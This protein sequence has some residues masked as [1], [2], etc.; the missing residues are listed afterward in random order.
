MEITESNTAKML[1]KNEVD[2]VDIE[3]NIGGCGFA[4][5]VER[6]L[7]EKYGTNKTK[8]SWFHQSKNK[9]ARILSNS[10]WIMDHNYY[11]VNWKDK[12]PEYYK[13]MTTYQ[14]EGKNKNNDA[15]DATTGT[16]EK[17]NKTSGVSVLK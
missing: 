5:S 17:L 4:R 13:A 3:S 15:P 11:P 7:K 1:Y 6:I 10:T 12:W 14:R 9:I 2:L 8:I 16:A